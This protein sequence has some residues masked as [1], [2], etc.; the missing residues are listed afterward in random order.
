MIR[1]NARSVRWSGG[2][3]CSPSR[4]ARVYL[5]EVKKA[6]VL[7]TVLFSACAGTEPL[8]GQ[9][10]TQEFVFF[11]NS[12]GSFSHVLQSDWRPAVEGGFIR[13]NDRQRI[14]AMDVI[15]IRPRVQLDIEGLVYVR[16]M[17]RNGSTSLS[18][19]F[20]LWVREGSQ[21]MFGT[22]RSLDLMQVAPQTWLRPNDFRLLSER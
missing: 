5:R 2:K 13:I 18:G 6:V 11:T 1:A 21:D 19:M 4:S 17:R 16:L 10:D 3:N 20:D 7:L 9:V 12:G 8:P 14:M 15:L 22:N